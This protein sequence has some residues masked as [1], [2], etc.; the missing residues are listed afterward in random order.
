MGIS[1]ESIRRDISDP[2]ADWSDTLDDASLVFCAV[3]EQIRTAAC[4]LVEDDNK[5]TQSIGVALFGALYLA[6][7]GKRLMDD[8][9]SGAIRKGANH[10]E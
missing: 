5:G 1:L 2:A 3:I 4:E 8:G 6:E 7:I 9:H 10:E